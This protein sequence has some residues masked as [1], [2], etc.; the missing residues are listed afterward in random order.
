VKKETRWGDWEIG[1]IAEQ[2]FW[3]KHRL[4]SED[5]GT[6]ADTSPACSEETLHG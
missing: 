1:R 2:H 3:D 6:T 4:F 5:M